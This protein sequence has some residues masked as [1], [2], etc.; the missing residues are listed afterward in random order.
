MTR[1]GRMEGRNVGEEAKG[2]VIESWLIKH[3]FLYTGA[4]RH[5]FILSIRDGTVEINSLKR[6]LVITSFHSLILLSILVFC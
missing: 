2:S 3:G 5:P 4:T 1:K 6:W